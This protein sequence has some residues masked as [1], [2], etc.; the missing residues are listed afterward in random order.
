MFHALYFN[1]V[2]RDAEDIAEDG[3]AGIK[4]VLRLLEIVRFRIVV[5]IEGYLV[6]TGQRMQDAQMFFTR[7]YSMRSVKRSR[8][9]RVM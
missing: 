1:I 4:S 5:H 2:Q 9:T 6:D 3:F 8:C 7:S